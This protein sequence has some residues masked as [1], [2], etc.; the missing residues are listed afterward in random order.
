M[1]LEVEVN[2]NRV[3]T[4]KGEHY[5]QQNPE[6]PLCRIHWR[7]LQSIFLIHVSVSTIK[8]LVEK[9]GFRVLK[10]VKLGIVS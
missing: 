1:R 6:D 8:A 10:A 9:R 5:I 4:E 2:V 7:I 3:P